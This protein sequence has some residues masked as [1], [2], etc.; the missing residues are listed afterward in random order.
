MDVLKN[1]RYR[2]YDRVSRYVRFPYYYHS[3]D[4]KYIYGTTNQLLATTYYSLHK[5]VRG[6]TPD[7]LALK[8][9]NNPTYYWVILDFNRMQD[10]FEELVEGSYIKI[11]TFSTIQYKE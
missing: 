1:K 8:Y 7:S 11:P 3:K 10:P 9:Y 2:S 4:N 5:V 6:D